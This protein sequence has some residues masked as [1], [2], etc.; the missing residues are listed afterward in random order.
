MAR[1]LMSK[2]SLEDE[3]SS[4][5]EP[6]DEAALAETQQECDNCVSEI[7][8]TVDDI[9]EAQELQSVLEDKDA[10]LAAAQQEGATEMDQA[11]AVAAANEALSLV[12][13]RLGI[14]DSGYTVSYESYKDGGSSLDNAISLSRE[15]IK[16]VFQTILKA[17]QAAWNWIVDKVMSFFKMIGKLLGLSKKNVDEAEKNYAEA[18]KTFND[19]KKDDSELSKIDIDNILND[20]INTDEFKNAGGLSKQTDFVFRE[21]KNRLG[22]K[23]GSEF[24]VSTYTRPGR[25]GSGAHVT[26]GIY[27]DPL[28]INA[29]KENR[30]YNNISC[31]VLSALLT[32]TQGSNRLKVA[33]DISK[34]V[35][36][37]RIILKNMKVENTGIGMTNSIVCNSSV[38]AD[39]ID[40]SARFYAYFIADEQDFEKSLEYDKQ[41]RETYE[42]E[43]LES[44]KEYEKHASKE[45]IMDSGNSGFSIGCDL[46]NVTFKNN[47]GVDE[48]VYR[49]VQLSY[50]NSRGWHVMEVRGNAGVVGGPNIN[51]G[52]D[53]LPKLLS[54]N[55]TVDVTKYPTIRER[56][57]DMKTLV[58]H[59]DSFSNKVNEYAKKYKEAITI[60]QKALNGLVNKTNAQS[61]PEYMLRDL[62]MLTQFN[63]QVGTKYIS[64]AMKLVSEVTKYSNHVA[65]IVNKCAATIT[66]RTVIGAQNDEVYGHVLL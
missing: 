51:M 52:T 54:G 5:V 30:R 28:A 53:T 19:A 39:V 31:S 56:L 55:T 58:T 25:F 3:L 12:K 23:K 2:L 11:V 32:A 59:V 50:S 21:L 44:A 18:E 38:I 16:E 63:R 40:T 61:I 13:T 36:V 6:V 46:S 37:E 66:G 42:K 26:T 48:S 47:T 14:Q 4:T 45:L 10:D 33:E 9:D 62:Y 17:L 57:R 64:D 8:D 34:C 15:G 22:S 20:L 7:S 27:G 60:G 1:N 49:G 24:G 43:M 41:T 35:P 29:N 65:K